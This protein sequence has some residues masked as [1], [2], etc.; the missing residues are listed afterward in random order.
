MIFEGY[1][2]NSVDL[3][4]F[5]EFYFKEIVEIEP[6]VGLVFYGEIFTEDIDVEVIREMVA[7]EIPDDLTSVTTEINPLVWNESGVPLAAALFFY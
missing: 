2:A 7:N 5:F 6:C 4:N 1:A 3:E